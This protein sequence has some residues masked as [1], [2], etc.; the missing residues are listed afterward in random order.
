M[1]T[2]WPNPCSGETSEGGGDRDQLCLESKAGGGRDPQEEGGEGGRRGGGGA[3]SELHGGQGRRF[4]GT[5]GKVERSNAATKVD[6]H[7]L[8]HVPGEGEAGAGEH[9]ER[10]GGG[11]DE[12]HEVRRE[13]DDQDCAGQDEEEGRRMANKVVAQNAIRLN[14]SFTVFASWFLSC[15][16]CFTWALPW[17]SLFNCAIFGKYFGSQMTF[18]HYPFPW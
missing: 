13:H 12:D 8:R 15:A 11:D 9:V 10:G 14:Q 5:I 16:Y 1:T 2:F 17:W 4:A 18:S 7:F 3:G 6:S